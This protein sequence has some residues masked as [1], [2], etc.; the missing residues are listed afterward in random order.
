MTCKICYETS[1]IILILNC[2][3][4]ITQSKGYWEYNS[5]FSILLIRTT[6]C[7]ELPWSKLT[8]LLVNGLGPI[9]NES[10]DLVEVHD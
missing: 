5:N 9:R 1:T 10:A 8:F 2:M 6:V 4:L 3:A 7:F